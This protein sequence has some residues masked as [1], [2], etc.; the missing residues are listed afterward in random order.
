M[1]PVAGYIPPRLE[2]G[3]E[4]TTGFG[5]GEIEFNIIDPYKIVS[6]STY[7]LSFMDDST[8]SFLNGDGPELFF[9]LTSG[10]LLVNLTNG[11]TLLRPSQDF[12]PATL[13]DFLQEGFN[14]IIRNVSEPNLASAV[15][16]KG[17]SNLTVWL[18]STGGKAVS[19]DYE[20]RILDMGADTSINGTPTNYQIWDVTDPK[21]PF[22]APFRLNLN[23]NKPD[24]L[25]GYLGNEDNVWIYAQPQTQNDGSITYKKST[26]RITFSLPAGADAATPITEPKK[27]DI[28]RITLKK[29]F[30]RL[31]VFEF[32][33]IGNEIQRQEA[34]NHLSDIFVVPN[35]YLAVSTLERRMISED[36]GRGDRRIDFVNLPTECTIKI[37]TVAGRLVREIHHSSTVDK[38]RA[39][40]DL[41][42][43]DGLEVSQGYYFYHVE[44]PG[45]GE[46]TGKFAIIK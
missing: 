12:S 18:T 4:H 28:M 9:G 5:T 26:W 19:R 43:K 33:I 17:N 42:T 40:W 29:P 20:F 31:D 7:Q 2:Q 25:K 15:W 30:D 22:K 3:L 41:R 32:K 35:P 10:A 24:S 8:L 38:G 21:A 36:Y 27:G 11:D 46:K 39:I 13:S 14:L 34:T 23:R 45:I 6:N 1:E 37:F 16:L 44:A